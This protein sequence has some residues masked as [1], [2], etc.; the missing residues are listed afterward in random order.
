MVLKLEL[1]SIV[2]RGRQ[3]ISN[4]SFINA[5][6]ARVLPMAEKLRATVI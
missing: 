1:I 6:G 4:I 5:K 3:C 2:T